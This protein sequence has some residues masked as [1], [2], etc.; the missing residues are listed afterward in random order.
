[1]K[2]TLKDALA[3]RREGSKETLRNKIYQPVANIFLYIFY[4]LGLSGNTV[5][6]LVLLLSIVA[7]IL[8]IVPLKWTLITGIL[9]FVLAQLLDFID[10]DIARLNK[11]CSI[12]GE[13]L[14]AIHHI[15]EMIFIPIGLGVYCYFYDNPFI[16]GAPE[17]TIILLLAGFITSV[18]LLGLEQFKFY[19]LNFLGH[20]PGTEL[21]LMNFP[22]VIF[23]GIW[24]K[25]WY[26]IIL[27]CVLLNY[28]MF[29]FRLLFLW[30][31]VRVPVVLLM[32]YM[33]CKKYDQNE[34]RNN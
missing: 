21:H 19:M 27:L 16:S 13:W 34:V 23:Y 11:Q 22:E 6:W 4:N 31:S 29:A 10:G 3:I 2:I 17:Q 15:L 5:S 12:K 25:A 8:C 32:F 24:M 28:P 30:A 18:L 7:S 1:M 9:L 14:D 26:W 20:K 33:E